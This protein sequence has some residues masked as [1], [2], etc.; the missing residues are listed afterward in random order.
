M[1]E[2]I[3]VNIK[4][5]G[6]LGLLI[7][8]ALE[9][10]SIPF[11]GI[12]VVLGYGYIFNK[13]IYEIL[14]IATAMSLV[15]TL[16]SYIPYYIGIKVEEKIKKF[17][18]SKL[19]KAQDIMDKY[20]DLSI[21]LTRPFAIGNYIA[22]LA[23]VMKIKP[24]KYGILTFFGILPWSFIMIYLGKVSK[25]NL[26]IAKKIIGEYHIYVMLLVIVLIAVYININL[27]RK[28]ILYQ[29]GK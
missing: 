3:L 24:W 7:V 17:S 14:W 19:Q 12:I 21:A 5:F 2:S 9:G 26:D 20:G 23:G 11:P 25:G 4:G 27:L 15:Y 18:Q 6:F 29:K 28:R 16:F 8:M 13:G 10:A 1:I 22:Y